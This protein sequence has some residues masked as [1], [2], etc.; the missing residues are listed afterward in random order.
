[1]NNCSFIGRLTK[2]PEERAVGE[3]RVVTFTLA[4][5]R[6]AK[7]KT[8]DFIPCQAW[9]KTGDVVINYVRKGDQVGI[10]GALEIRQYDKDGERR[11]AFSINVSS[12]DLLAGKRSEPAP[13][14]AP[15]PVKA[16]PLIG[17]EYLIGG[18][19]ENDASLPF[20]IC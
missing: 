20:N 10:T 19:L 7:E 16:P 15:E 12:L 3:Y 2:D 14:P 11:T 1:M 13:T 5:D 6:R 17:D 4:V 8:T 9:N 18:G